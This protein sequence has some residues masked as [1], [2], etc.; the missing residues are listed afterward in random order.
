LAVAA[1]VE[2][3]AVDAADGAGVVDARVHA[4]REGLR[5]AA[6]SYVALCN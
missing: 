3:V 4:C 2:V 1:V 6:G 5:V